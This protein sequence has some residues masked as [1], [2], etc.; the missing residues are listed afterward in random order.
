VGDPAA[1]NSAIRALCDFLSK[2]S[3]S[4]VRKYTPAGENIDAV[5]D[6]RAVFQQGHRDLA[7]ETMPPFLLPPKGRYGLR[8]YEK[9]FCADPKSD[10]FTMRGIDRRN[11]CMVIVRPD[12]F[13]AHILPLDGTAQLAAF[14]DGFMMAGG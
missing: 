2:D 10:V 4:P 1:P 5:I 6:V 14:F 11:G 7:I 12:Q 3:Q 8:D 13:V 9:M